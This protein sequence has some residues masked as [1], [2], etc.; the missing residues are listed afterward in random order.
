MVRGVLAAETG[1]AP[2][3]P[4]VEK[5]LAWASRDAKASDYD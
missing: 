5:L 3:V 4:E 1:W 2:V